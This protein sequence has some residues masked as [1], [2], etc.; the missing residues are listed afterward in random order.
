MCIQGMFVI[1]LRFVVPLLIGVRWKAPFCFK[2]KPINSA[3][4]KDQKLVSLF[5]KIWYCNRLLITVPLNI[6]R[7]YGRPKWILVGQMLK[8]VGKWP[9]ADCYF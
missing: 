3:R 9:M 1:L 6:Y 7:N 5:L 2:D 4:N 8:L